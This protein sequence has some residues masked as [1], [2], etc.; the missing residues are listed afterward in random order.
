MRRAL[1]HLLLACPFEA[2]HLRRLL[3]LTRRRQEEMRRK[4]TGMTAMDLGEWV[5]GVRVFV[6]D[7]VKGCCGSHV[8]RMSISCRLRKSIAKRPSLLLH[9]LCKL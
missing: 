5:A 6:E 3:L 1:G 4:R 9:G 2:D 7:V 8:R